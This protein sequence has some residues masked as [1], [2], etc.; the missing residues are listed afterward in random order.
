MVQPKKHRHMSDPE[1]PKI[2]QY[3][4]GSSNISNST[5]WVASIIDFGLSS[6][7]VPMSS[8]S[9][10]SGCFDFVNMEVDNT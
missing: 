5:D 1:D 10:S 8:P 4:F 6:L 3:N 9:F 2:N 7:D